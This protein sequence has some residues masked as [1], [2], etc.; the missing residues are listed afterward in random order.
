MD[1]ALKSSKNSRSSEENETTSQGTLDD[2]DATNSSVNS[3]STQVNVPNSQDI[4]EASTLEN[5]TAFHP[6][7]ASTPGQYNECN[8]SK[9]KC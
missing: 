8:I 5:S 1:A 6:L 9:I 7:T 4:S 2:A 3:Q